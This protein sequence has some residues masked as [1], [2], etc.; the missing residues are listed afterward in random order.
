MASRHGA[1]EAIP[2]PVRT[3]RGIC[4]AMACYNEQDAVETVVREA[5]EEL[6]RLTDDWEVLVVNDASTDRT[7]EILEG[8]QR[9]IRRLR[10]VHHPY[11]IGFRGYQLSLIVNAGKDYVY[12]V[13]ADG[14]FRMHEMRRMLP[15]LEDGADIVIGVRRDK[16]YG[17][18]R[19]AVSK[20]FNGLVK[21]LFGE[22]LEDAGSVRMVRRAPYL[23][24]R[25]ISRSAFI[26]AEKLIRASR[27]GLRIEKVTVERY[28]RLGGRPKGGRPTVVMRAFVDLWR[29]WFDLQFRPE[30]PQ[31][32]P[33]GREAGKR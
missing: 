11:R 23:R 18:Y 6:G 21:K 33:S 15:L 26:N 1:E 2:P 5:V 31:W 24:I 28:P 19:S 4:V 30:S 8:L 12:Q 9:E 27:R 20:A 13:S 7:R 17:G 3:E 29:V 16:R 22:D 32:R 25:V 14:E 10:V